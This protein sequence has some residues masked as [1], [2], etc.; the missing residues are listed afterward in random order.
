MTTTRPSRSRRAARPTPSTASSAPST[1]SRR[2][3][4]IAACASSAT[5]SRPRGACS[6]ATTAPRRRASRAF[7]TASEAHRLG[8]NMPGKRWSARVA[9]RSNALDL[10]QGVFARPDAKSIA[11]SL[12]RSA[13]HDVL[14]PELPPDLARAVDL[15]VLLVDAVDLQRH[16]PLRLDLLGDGESR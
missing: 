10:D 2:P 9:A 1:C 3:A 11:R 13:Y 7:A 6:A 4:S 8:A 15:V 14:A 16:D 12:K 5:G